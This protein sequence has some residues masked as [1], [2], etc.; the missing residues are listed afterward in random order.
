MQERSNQTSESDPTKVKWASWV[1]QNGVG[2]YPHAENTSQYRPHQ[3]CEMRYL[4]REFCWVCR[5]AF[6]DKIYS[7]ISSIDQYVPSSTNVNVAQES[8]FS[9]EVLEPNPNTLKIEWVLNGNEIANDVKSV[10]LTPQLL[11][12]N[13]VLTVN[14]LDETSFTHNVNHATQNTKTVVWTITNDVT[15]NQISEIEEY[16]SRLFV[17]PNPASEK[18]TIDLNTDFKGETTWELW[19]ATGIRVDSG[20]LNSN[21]KSLV[22]INLLNYDELVSGVYFVKI[23]LDGNMLIRKVVVN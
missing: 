16:S 1:N 20:S 12:P 4:N 5:E 8:V 23:N 11:E 21:S 17:Y 10:D 7:L 18:I 14:V 9:I 6:V 2:V 22:E 3:N 19:T 13:N 15:G